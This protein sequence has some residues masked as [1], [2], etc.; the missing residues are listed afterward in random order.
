VTQ[1]LP[2]LA[3][4]KVGG[5]TGLLAGALGDLPAL[6]AEGRLRAVVVH[7][8]GP[9]VS[10]LMERLGLPVTF[11]GGLR[12]TDPDALDSAVMVLRGRVNTDLVASL[13]RLGVRAVGLSGVDAG[14]VRAKPHSDPALGLVGQASEVRS[15]L[16]ELLVAQ[17]MV[18]CVAPLAL[19]GDGI[20]RN[21]NADTMC[22][23]L[24]GALSAKWTVFLTDVPGVLRGNGSLAEHLST[25]EVEALI[26]SG[27][28]FGGMIPKVRACLEALKH[29]ARAVYITDGRRRGDLTELFTD[30]TTRGTLITE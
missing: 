21:L 27:E 11:K 8:G 19:D 5:N 10:Q 13:V 3:V 17:G 12:V 6:L 26:L 29:G 2:P 24:A 20:V 4:F 18:P 14:M 16:L 7:G 1:S 25:D 15:E 9:A 23:A 28:I 30:G 22:G